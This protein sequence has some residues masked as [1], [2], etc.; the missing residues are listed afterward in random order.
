VAPLPVLESHISH[1]RFESPL[2]SQS[3][4][5]DNASKN[6]SE[7][8]DY[9]KRILIKFEMLKFESNAKLN[10]E[11]RPTAPVWRLL[12][13]LRLRL[14]HRP[15]GAGHAIAVTLEPDSIAR[16]RRCATAAFTWR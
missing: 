7:Y 11:T 1:K 4:F 3:H 9:L 14:E 15:P 5:E 2:S 12:A 16:L 8:C 10:Q 6:R 13:V